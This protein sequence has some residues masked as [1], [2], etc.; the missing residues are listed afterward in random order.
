MVYGLGDKGVD[1]LAEEHGLDRGGIVW[2]E[3]NKEVKER[4]IQHVL[5]VSNFRACLTLALSG[6]HEAE[7]HWLRGESPKLR[8]E[9]YYY[10]VF[11]SSSFKAIGMC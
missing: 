10:S 1:L 3:K 2:Q 9:V 8:Q 7:L 11:I 5:M 4:Y 6:S